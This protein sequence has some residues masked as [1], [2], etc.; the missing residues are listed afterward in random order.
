[1]KFNLSESQVLFLCKNDTSFLESFVRTALPLIERSSAPTV[2]DKARELIVKAR[3]TPGSGAIWAIKQLREW[4]AKNGGDIGLAKAKELVVKYD[5]DPGVETMAE[6][7]AKIACDDNNVG[8]KIIAIK[9]LRDWSTTVPVERLKGYDFYTREGDGKTVLG[10]AQAK[11]L[12]EKYMN[13]E[14]S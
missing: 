1:M 7:Y 9:N 3:R 10:L 6:L 5:P 12:I 14:R 2:D 4:T 8:A 13:Q 11:M